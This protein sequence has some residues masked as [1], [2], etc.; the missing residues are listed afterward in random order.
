[1]HHCFKL[2]RLCR[3]LDPAEQA[4]LRRLPETHVND[5][6]AFAWTDRELLVAFADVRSRLLH[7]QGEGVVARRQQTAQVHVG[8][9][10]VFVDATA[11]PALGSARPPAK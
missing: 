2:K 1:M 9:D 7:V 6:R 10:V 5:R 3:D 4:H 8:D 11:V